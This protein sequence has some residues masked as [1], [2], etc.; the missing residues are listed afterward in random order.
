MSVLGNT[1]RLLVERAEAGFGAAGAAQQCFPARLGTHIGSKADER[2]PASSFPSGTD[3]PP[4]RKQRGVVA[5]KLGIAL[6]KVSAVLVAGLILIY[7]VTT[8]VSTCCAPGYGNRIG[9]PRRVA[10]KSSSAEAVENRRPNPNHGPAGMAVVLTGL[11]VC[12]DLC[13]GAGELAKRTFVESVRI[14]E[15]SYLRKNRR[16][17][18]RRDR[19]THGLYH[20]RPVAPRKYD[21]SLFTPSK[22]RPVAA[23]AA[24]P[25]GT[26][27]RSASITTN[28]PRIRK[29]VTHAG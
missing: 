20:Q 13:S 9:T 19:R 22:S 4:R 15:G 27:T 21:I 23:I 12:Q 2:G 11:S 10:S 24:E 7:V 26:S 3:Q 8:A 18:R 14:A 16:S 29:S 1:A 6:G 5:K 28:A 25:S 17:A